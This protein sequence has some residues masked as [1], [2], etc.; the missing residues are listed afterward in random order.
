MFQGHL[1]KYRTYNELINCY[2]FD[3]LVFAFPQENFEGFQP[4]INHEI[5]FV[6]VDNYQ[7]GTASVNA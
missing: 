7:E 2:S 1:G 3:G 5:S 6:L 4:I